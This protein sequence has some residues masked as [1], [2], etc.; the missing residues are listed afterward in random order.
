[1]DASLYGVDVG[2]LLLLT[3]NS[4]LQVTSTWGTVLGG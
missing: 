2:I 4:N 1:M 3:R